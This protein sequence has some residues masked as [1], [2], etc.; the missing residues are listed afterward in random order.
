MPGI[1]DKKSKEIEIKLIARLRKHKGQ[2]RSSSPWA[3]ASKSCKER[4]EQGLL[5]SLDF[6]KE[7]LDPGTR[8]SS[9]P[10]KQVEPGR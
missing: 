10:S 7:L 4:H 5:H 3:N 8:R 2:P 6:L 9:R 1:P